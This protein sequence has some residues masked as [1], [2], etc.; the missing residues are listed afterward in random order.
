MRIQLQR[1]FHVDFNDNQDFKDNLD[2]NNNEFN[3]NENIYNTR[4]ISTL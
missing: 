2:F 4:H 1:V 3:D